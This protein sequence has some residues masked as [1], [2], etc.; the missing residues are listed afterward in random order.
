MVQEDS[1]ARRPH[2]LLQLT[3][4]VFLVLATGRVDACVVA[5]IDSGVALLVHIQRL[6]DD[7]VVG[8]TNHHISVCVEPTVQ[9]SVAKA[10]LIVRS[11]ESECTACHTHFLRA[12]WTLDRFLGLCEFSRGI[13][14]GRWGQAGA[15]LWRSHV[16]SEAGRERGRS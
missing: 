4:D 15:G 16:V 1:V 8:D 2:D 7:V 3:V 10:L 13:P 14:L 11:H 12:T 6:F 9:G 5:G